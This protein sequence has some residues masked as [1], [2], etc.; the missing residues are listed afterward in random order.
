MQKLNKHLKH[1]F[2]YV[3]TVLMF[4]VIV[5]VNCTQA[6]AG[7]MARETESNKKEQQLIQKIKI[8]H[9]VFPTQ[10]DEFALYATLVHRG[11]LSDYVNDSYD[12]NF[13]ENDYKDG[14]NATVDAVKNIGANAQAQ[15]ADLLLAA[16]IVMLDSSGW[17]LPGAQYSDEKYQKALAGSKLVGNMLDGN[18]LEDLLGN[19]FNTLFCGVGATADTIIATPIEFG[20]SLLEGNGDTVFQSK[21]A[22][23][24]T[25]KNVC[26][27]GFVGGTYSDVKNFSPVGKTEEETKKLEEQYQLKKDKIAEEII[28]L[29]QHFRGESDVC[30]VNPSSNGDYS[31]WKQYG[32]SWSDISMGDGTISRYGCLLTSMAIQIARAGTAVTNLPSGFTTFNPGAFVTSLKNNGGVDDNANFTGTGWQKIASNVKITEQSV[33]NVNTTSEL[34][35]V[36]SAELATGAEEKYQKYLIIKISATGHSQHWIAIDSVTN[37]SV[38]LMDPGAT[39]TTLDENYDNWVVSAYKVLYA[40]DVPFGQGGTSIN[41]NNYCNNGGEGIFPGTK[42]TDL[43][44]DQLKTLTAVCIREQGEDIEGVKFEASLMANLFELRRNGEGG[45]TGLYNY[46]NN[47]GWFGSPGFHNIN[48]SR[49]TDELK[50]AVKEVLVDGNR[51]LPPY[52]NEHDCWFCNSRNTCSNGNLGDICYLEIDGQRYNDKLFIKDKNNYI[53]DKTVIHN[54]YSSVYTF[55]AFPPSGGDPFGYTADAK[56]KFQNT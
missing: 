49:V 9:E 8:I 33:N 1:T 20:A 11:T 13:N 46:V 7:L 37:D 42:Y 50:T 17:F 25:M 21:V 35:K 23:Y 12:P 51:V 14:I 18:P 2:K 36:L 6:S 48:L 31:S 32:E 30:V 53:T 45:A 34:A 4:F 5:F 43:T 29:A 19:G 15:S 22:R 54:V 10:V 52:V 28:E 3:F 55:Y 27:K 16:T 24:V 44:E 41:T 26:E 47:G 40:T 39:G 38:T 56:N